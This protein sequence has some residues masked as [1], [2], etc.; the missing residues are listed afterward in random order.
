MNYR[1]IYEK[2]VSRAQLRVKP[3]GY[4]E[5][6]HVLPKCLGGTDEKENIAVLT[7][8]EHYLAHQ[9]LVKMYPGDYRL[10]YAALRMSVHP[11]GNRVTNKLYGWIRKACSKAHPMYDPK[12]KSTISAFRKKVWEDPEYK[13]LM[14]ELVQGNKNPMYGKK[15]DLSPTYG[16][17]VANN[18]KECRK[19]KPG[20]IPEGWELGYLNMKGSSH[21]MHGRKH[22]EEAK[23][24]MA[25]TL[26]KVYKCD[27]CGKEMSAGSM[28][29]HH[30]HSGHKGKTLL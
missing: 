7:P 30:K 8:E 10:T 21:P 16:T 11:N 5:K 23:I 1:A 27:V 17:V 6:H 12:I 19:F 15:K 18:G 28:G 3:K 2:L 4:V 22:T 24:K 20:E 14:S 29:I 13:K 9:L 25:K 26:N